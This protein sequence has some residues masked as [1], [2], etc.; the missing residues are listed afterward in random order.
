MYNYLNN[1]LFF[2]L[3]KEWQQQQLIAL[4]LKI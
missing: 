1:Y 2:N 4:P 3:L